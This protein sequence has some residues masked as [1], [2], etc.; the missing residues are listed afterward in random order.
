MPKLIIPKTYVPVKSPLIFLAGPIG[1]A[2]NWQDEAIN[3]LFS[4]DSD[5]VIASPRRGIR[6]SIAPYILTGNEN[7]FHRQRAWERH[8]L[9][10]ASKTGAIMFWLPGEAEHK[11]EK[12]YGAMTRLE[13]GQWMTDYRHNPEVRFCVGSDGKFP[14]L[15]TIKYDL[16]LDA[17]D[18]EIKNSLE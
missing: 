14:E 17:P 18:K 10:I 3:H 7:F 16:L 8:Y 1:S 4:L 6:E 9:D 12:V 11:C 15:D 13:L 5:L 2:P